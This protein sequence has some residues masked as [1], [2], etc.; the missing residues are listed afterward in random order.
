MTEPSGT[1][2]PSPPVKTSKK[3]WLL[4][5]AVSLATALA[6]ISPFFWLGDASGHDFSFHA[7]SWMDVVAQWREGIFYPR[8][9]QGA[10]FGFGEPR[11]IFYPPLSWMFGAALSFVVRWEFVPG[12]FI[13][14]TQML[15]GVSAFVLARRMVSRNGALIA[16]FCYAA[17]PY[18][19][20]IV[21]MRSDFA[22]QLAMVFF[23]LLVLAAF[24]LFGFLETR[25][26][27]EGR[28]IV[29]FAML[30]AA[31]W[32]T[33]APA[34]VVATYSLG[35][36]CIYAA[37]VTR[38]TR[39]LVGG[40]VSI[41]LGFGLS[42]FFLIPAVYEQRWV[43]I[44]QALVVGLRH[45]ENFLYAVTK[46]REHDAFNH[47]ASSA[48]V[49][50]MVLTAI[51]AAACL[52]KWQKLPVAPAQRGS[53][54]ALLVIFGASVFLMVPVSNIL[55]NLLPELR[56]VQFPWRWM[57]ILAVPF[58]CFAGAAISQRFSTRVAAST[59]MVA[60]VAMLA[61]AA[62][63]MV[64]HTWWDTE[65]IPVLQE[66]IGR[67]EG[68]EGVDEYDPAGD[69]HSSLPENS[70]R[71]EILAPEEGDSVAAD[72]RVGAR[73]NIDRWSAEEKKLRVSLRE[74]ARL[75]L[76]LLNYPA[77]QVRVNG[78]EQKFEQAEQ[79]GEINP[80]VLS[81]SAGNS[82]I[83]VRFI[84]TADRTIGAALSGVSVLIALVLLLR[85]PRTVN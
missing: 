44:N 41:A 13:V 60:L 20:L 55:W 35:L 48:A 83:E 14:L 24:E 7:A 77:W 18:A 21:Y 19:L 72:P 65:D 67:D 8:W 54:N 42:G 5:V 40:A 16:A 66:A 76:R 73:I 2:L 80:I 30:F 37:Y 85:R 62:T 39:P 74:P 32:L 70:A 11:F 25:A 79:T 59:A 22:E 10:N 69:D 58:G 52:T 3:D 43:S 50:M 6:V 84:R 71:A 53:W 23:P 33:N 81:L 56:F 36:L 78:E 31:V 9:N 38:T 26:R 12:V 29:G 45:S 63:Y 61:G 49:L 1:S 46:D 75:S 27:T 15:A 51:F 28:G 17:N 4:A 82:D 47:I 68:F 34:A 57:S 64:R